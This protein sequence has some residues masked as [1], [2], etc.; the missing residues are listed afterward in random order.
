M[1]VTGHDSGFSRGME[2]LRKMY[3]LTGQ[4]KEARSPLEQAIEALNQGDAV[5]REAARGGH[6]RAELVRKAYGL[7]EQ[8]N[9]LAGG[10]RQGFEALKPEL[11]EWLA[12]AGQDGLKDLAKEMDLTAHCQ[13][14]IAISCSTQ[15]AAKV[16]YADAIFEKTLRK[17]SRESLE[18]SLEL[19]QTAYQIFRQ[20]KEAKTEA[21]D[22]V[23]QENGQHIKSLFADWGYAYFALGNDA[24]NRSRDIIKAAHARMGPTI[25]EWLRARELTRS[26]L[27]WYSLLDKLKGTADA[28][29]VEFKTVP[30]RL[31][32]VLKERISQLQDEV[33]KTK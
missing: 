25:S 24:Y 21:A 1:E 15:A 22:S 33:E 2:L 18:A 29:G 9:R 7:Y 23:L 3:T 11:Q 4:Y 10:A 28:E 16:H 13:L 20:L 5:V 27:K 14:S 12:E 31:Y 17:G 19:C 32:P 26:A 6:A 8:A 30:G